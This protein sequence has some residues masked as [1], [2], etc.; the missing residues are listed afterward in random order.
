M[1]INDL[2]SGAQFARAT[3]S[4][5]GILNSFAG[6]EA[7]W[8]IQ[9]GSY[10]GVAFHVFKSVVPYKAGLDQIQDS[11]GRR[12]VKYQFPY[13]DGQTTDD[14]GR[15]PGTYSF[16]IILHGR[17]YLSGYKKL[18][19]ELNKPTPGTLIHP[20]LGPLTCV[21][22]DY[23]I[24]HRSSDRKAMAISLT[25]IEHN[26][27]IGSLTNIKDAVS[28]KGAI[29]RALEVFNTINNAR[30]RVLGFVKFA[31]SLKNQ[32][33]AL[34]DIYKNDSAK[35]LSRINKA[36]NPN[37][38]SSDIP[39]LVPVNQGGILNQSGER[40][41]ETFL[42][43][44]SPSD[45]LNNVPISTMEENETAA[46]TSQQL[47]VEINNLRINAQEIIN[48][49]STGEGSLEFYQ[50]ILDL[51]AT[52]VVMQEAYETGLSSSRAGIRTYEVPRNM[53]I[54]EVAFLSNV[55]LERVNEI[56]ILNPQILSFNWITTGTRV[57]VPVL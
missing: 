44:A 27:T 19:A 48:L 36:F 24:T 33:T 52:A 14:L 46:V 38:S 10:N 4:L 45:P 3:G 51:K 21:M 1:S 47:E 50:E 35:T 32:I 26:F 23:Q 8:D 18:F 53:S 11:G 9:E 55:P 16:N 57:I 17:D 54:R 13:I 22:E 7:E 56:E 39:G 12:K 31:Q 29:A 34:L 49:M 25:M 40:T 41:Q 43:S 37:G 15:K 2:N 20:V 5:S 30:L 28:V 6:R 42:T